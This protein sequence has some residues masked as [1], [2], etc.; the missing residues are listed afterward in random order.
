MNGM[1]Q[2]SIDGASRL[3]GFLSWYLSPVMPIIAL[4]VGDIKRNV[5]VRKH[6]LQSLAVFAS[7]SVFVILWMCAFVGFLAVTDGGR[8]RGSEPTMLVLSAPFYC[9]SIAYTLAILAFA[10]MAALGKPVN[11]PVL[12]PWADRRI[13]QFPG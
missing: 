9:I 10:I 4:L 1:Q 2:S 8:S 6:A 7:F 3:L 12:G 13:A 11:L 5:F